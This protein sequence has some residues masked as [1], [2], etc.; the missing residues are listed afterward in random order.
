MFFGKDKT[1][2]KRGKEAAGKEKDE[3]WDGLTPK[4]S[5]RREFTGA[6]QGCRGQDTVGITHS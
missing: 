5:H 1:A 6:E 2:R 4:R 3:T